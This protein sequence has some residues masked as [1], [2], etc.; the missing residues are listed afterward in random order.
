MERAAKRREWN[1]WELALK[2]MD[3]LWKETRD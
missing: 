3:V 2:E 1:V